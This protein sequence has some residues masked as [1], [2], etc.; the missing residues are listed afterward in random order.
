MYKTS[1]S[2]SIQGFQILDIPQIKVTRHYLALNKT[3]SGRKEGKPYADLV[4]ERPL[5]HLSL[6]PSDVTKN[7]NK[8]SQVFLG[9][10][11]YA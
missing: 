8:H 2:Q 10:P 7:Q 5:K 6:L 4:T 9:R 1:Q 11:I 3:Y